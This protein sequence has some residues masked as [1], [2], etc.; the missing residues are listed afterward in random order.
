[1]N[2]QQE[3][4]RGEK[5][6]KRT[7]FPLIIDAGVHA[8]V[9]RVRIN[10]SIPST[11]FGTCCACVRMYV[12]ACVCAHACVRPCKEVRWGRKGGG[13]GQACLGSIRF[14][15]AKGR[16]DVVEVIPIFG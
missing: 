16:K 2:K 12:C 13:G 14:E 6:P 4:E 5:V 1:M 15:G 9:R 10:P 3:T 11:V 7:P 8:V